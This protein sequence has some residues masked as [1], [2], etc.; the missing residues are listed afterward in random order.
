MK[1]IILLITWVSSLL[2]CDKL[3]AQASSDSSNKIISVDIKSRDAENDKKTFKIN[4]DSL[5]YKASMPANGK[6]NLLLHFL[7]KAKSII[8]EIGEPIDTRRKFD[9]RVTEYPIVFHINVICYEWKNGKE[10]KY[11][12]FSVTAKSKN[13]N[14]EKD[15]D[16]V[17]E[18]HHKIGDKDNIIDITLALNN[19]LKSYIKGKL[20]D[21]MDPILEFSPAK[22]K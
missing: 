14:I 20:A 2:T 17:F 4:F 11:G 1:R 12:S 8:I 18:V 10:V 7:R 3:S 22:N 21:S 9:K 13:E 16:I 19:E 15:S 6:T 5:L